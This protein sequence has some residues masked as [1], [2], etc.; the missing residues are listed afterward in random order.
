MSSSESTIRSNPD[1][2]VDS[3]SQVDRKNSVDLTGTTGI[4][5]SIKGPF[6]VQII[7]DAGIPLKNDRLTNVLNRCQS[8]SPKYQDAYFELID[9]KSLD[10]VKGVV[11]ISG[12]EGIFFP[13]SNSYCVGKTV[14]TGS[15][16]RLIATGGCV[17]IT[18]ESG[19]KMR[20]TDSNDIPLTIDSFELTI[21]GRKPIQKPGLWSSFSLDNFLK[22]TNGFV[23]IATGIA[24]IAIVLVRK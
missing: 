9:W 5:G 21:Q 24:L 11:F 14:L 7:D 16:P 22:I 12:I 10:D 1:M 23:Q 2:A 3:V 15:H 19:F 6:S 18:S 8:L 20:L 13:N 17:V 4:T